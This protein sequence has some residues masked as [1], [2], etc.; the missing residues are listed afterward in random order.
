[1]SE[2]AS[3]EGSSAHLS[4]DDILHFED[5]EEDSFSLPISQSESLEIEQESSKSEVEGK[6]VKG[7][8]FPKNSGYFKIFADK[9]NERYE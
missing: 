5:D 6:V 2:P 8:I 4:Q 1:M 9:I 3:T 7:F